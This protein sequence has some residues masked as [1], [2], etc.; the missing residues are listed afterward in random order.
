MMSTWSQM[1]AE[2][3]WLD[4]GS[5]VSLPRNI[6]R[7]AICA[8]P[9]GI[10][11]LPRL[12]LSDLVSWMERRALQCPFLGSERLL[13]GCLIAYGGQGLIIINGQDPEDEKRFTVAH[14]VAHFILD[15]LDIRKRVA[16]SLGVSALEVLDGRRLPTFEERANA[17]LSSATIGVH[18]HLMDRTQ[19][20]DIFQ[21]TVLKAENDADLLALELLAPA[22]EVW[23][24]LPVK[25]RSSFRE[26][27]EYATRILK[28]EFGLP[29]TVAK[30][31]A[32]QLVDSLTGGPSI[33]EWL[34]LR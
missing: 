19:D 10:V 11:L 32:Y 17:V 33:R 23:A 30:P 28:E 29:N 18:T 16:D 9:L 27:M 31:Y 20:G 22:K 14:E 4:A 21:G 3:F 1:T 15:Y 26:L 2:R 12:R 8:L 13:R 7:A 24:R 6:E 34:G 5:P 25:T